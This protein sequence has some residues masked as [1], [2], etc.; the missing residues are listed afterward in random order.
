MKITCTLIR[1]LTAQDVEVTYEDHASTH[2]F[3]DSC[4]G[5]L[6]AGAPLELDESEY[7]EILFVKDENEQE[8]E[9]SEIEFESF[10]QQILDY[11][12][13]KFDDYGYRIL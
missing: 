7:V 12:H 4:C 2:G 11:I 8:I 5:V 9:C 1:D 6:G 10:S 3:R 13:A